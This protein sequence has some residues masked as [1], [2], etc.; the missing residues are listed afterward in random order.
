MMEA[1]LSRSF[2]MKRM[3]SLALFAFV[4][5]ASAAL[6]DPVP[7]TAKPPQSCFFIS[8]FESWKAPDN[9]TI[10]I[11]V[12][13]NRFYRLDLSSSCPTLTYPDAHLITK[14]R[15]SSTVC[16]ALDW[17]L[18]VGQAAPRGFPMGCIVK[19]MTPLTPEQVAAIP[20][21]FKP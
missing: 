11:R 14:T 20:K 3:I 16:T 19:T 2:S 13:T 5:G 8:Q 1:A 12:N 7:A 18:S 9:K 15:G 10:Y 4:G 21:K 17:D 6:A